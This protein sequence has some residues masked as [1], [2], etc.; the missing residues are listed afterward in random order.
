MDGFDCLLPGSD[1]GFRYDYMAL[2]SKAKWL[3]YDLKEGRLTDGR[4]GGERYYVKTSL[5]FGECIYRNTRHK[6]FTRTL[7]HAWRSSVW[8][9]GNW[10]ELALVVNAIDKEWDVT[11]MA[12]LIFKSLG[13]NSFPQEISDQMDHP[14]AGKSIRN[15]LQTGCLPKPALDFYLRLV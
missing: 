3:G 7:P 14:V 5:S 1:G 10:R 6:T 4:D 12:D 11:C 8:Y 13:I 15:F 9:E 2:W